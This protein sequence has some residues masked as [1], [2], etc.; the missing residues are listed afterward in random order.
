MYCLTPRQDGSPLL[1]LTAQPLV[2]GPGRCEYVTDVNTLNIKV[3]LTGDGV[4]DHGEMV[5]KTRSWYSYSWESLVP[6][7]RV[8]AC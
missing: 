8:M 3:K 4:L 7:I 2:E 6:T 1:Y 5:H